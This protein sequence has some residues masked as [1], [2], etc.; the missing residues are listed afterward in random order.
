[1]TETICKSKSAA[2]AALDTIAGTMTRGTQ[3]EALCAIKDWIEKNFPQDLNEETKEKIEKIW[4]GSEWEQAGRQWLD[5]EMADPRYVPGTLASDGCHL[6]HTMINE[7]GDGSELVCYWHSGA[8]KW[9][10]IG[11][12]WPDIQQRQDIEP[13]EGETE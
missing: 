5:Q 7:P 3:K 12:F 11:Y 6:S 13:D 10:P 1:M 4:Q 8:G 9:E 2:L